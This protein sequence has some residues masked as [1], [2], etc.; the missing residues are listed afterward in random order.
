MIE[1]LNDVRS[2]SRSPPFPCFLWAQGT[3]ASAAAGACAASDG[4][5]LSDGGDDGAS[6]GDMS[7]DSDVAAAAAAA[8]GGGG[9]EDLAS[10]SEEEDDAVAAAAAGGDGGSAET[11]LEIYP[12]PQA[13]SG[14]ATVA[15]LGSMLGSHSSIFTPVVSV[16]LLL[17]RSTR[18]LL[19]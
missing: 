8:D 11:A 9:G 17:R 7:Q 19:S 16:F 5:P 13:V 12:V 18:T 6:S 3:A 4:E 14:G 1:S 15:D 2:F 10:S